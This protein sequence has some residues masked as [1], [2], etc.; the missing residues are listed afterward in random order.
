MDRVLRSMSFVERNTNTSQY[1]AIITLS[2][3]SIVVNVF[4]C[5]ATMYCWNAKMMQ[6]TRPILTLQKFIGCILLAISCIIFTGENST[7]NC[8]TRVFFFNLSFTFVLSPYMIKAIGLYNTLILS[9]QKKEFH[10]ANMI[11]QTLPM[12]PFLAIDIILVSCSLY[13]GNSRGATSYQDG[14]N[15]YCGYNHN[16]VLFGLE[17]GY[18]S[19]LIVV[20]WWYAYALRHVLSKFAA[21]YFVDSTLRA[22]LG[23]AVLAVWRLG[24]DVPTAIV[25]ASAAACF[26]SL[27]TAFVNT[28]PVVMI[29]TMGDQE[30]I[31]GIV[32]DLFDAKKR[33]EEVT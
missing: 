24:G 21:I 2:I 29:L 20:S 11:S 17:L 27:V 22:I 26:C 25:F 30:A 7:F 8:T 23:S 32:E 5:L 4:A 6:H 33:E 18:K 19:I 16:E 15:T 13:V 10:G 3:L 14:D 1:N 9:F 31:G 28:I 12:I